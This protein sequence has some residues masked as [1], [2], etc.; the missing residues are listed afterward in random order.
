MR[1]TLIIVL[2]LLGA[3]ACGAQAQELVYFGTQVGGG[4]IAALAGGVAG[5]LVGGLSGVVLGI[6]IEIT[7]HPRIQIYQSFEEIPEPEEPVPVRWGV[8]GAKVGFGLGVGTGAALGV[9]WVG[10]L[11]GV[12]GNVQGAWTGAFA[13][14]LAGVMLMTDMTEG[15]YPFSASRWSCKRTE[16]GTN[17]KFECGYESGYLSPVEILLSPMVLAALGATIGYNAAISVA[18]SV[19][20]VSARF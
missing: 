11:F 12:E 2:M 14:A 10:K 20:M 9:I 17:I 16:Q 15:K 7:R 5:T 6:P 18:I 8:M 1:S 13:G 4:T 3:V 19:P